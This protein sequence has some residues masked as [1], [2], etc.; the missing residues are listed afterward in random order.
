[1]MVYK[2][3]SAQLD[4]FLSRPSASRPPHRATKFA[5]PCPLSPVPLRSAAAMPMIS[6]V[7]AIT[8][9]LP[10]RSGDRSLARLNLRAINPTFG[11]FAR[12]SILWRA[13]RLA[14]DPHIGQR[15][16]FQNWAARAVRRHRHV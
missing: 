8:P 14:W 11:P 2:A 7:Y 6:T 1:M 12:W 10:K 3:P 15:P 5:T 4:Y 16:R 13:R 9:Y